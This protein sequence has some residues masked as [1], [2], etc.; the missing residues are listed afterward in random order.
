[1]KL[2]L[3]SNKQHQ[4]TVLSLM[5]EQKKQVVSK[6]TRPITIY[7]EYSLEIIKLNF[8]FPD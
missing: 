4:K 6:N 2:K 1:M 7:K 8:F 3:I 5:F